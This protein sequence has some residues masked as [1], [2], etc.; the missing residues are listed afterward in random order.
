M[1][2]NQPKEMT[3][4]TDLFKLHHEAVEDLTHSMQAAFAERAA[5][6]RDEDEFVQQALP[7]YSRFSTMMLGAYLMT[8]QQIQRPTPPVVQ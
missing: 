3:V 2:P 5:R 8:V 7:L 1:N 6:A 4:N